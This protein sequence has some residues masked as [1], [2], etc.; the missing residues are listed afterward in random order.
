MEI[1]ELIIFECRRLCYFM[2]DSEKDA[3][4]I[5]TKRSNCRREVSTLSGLKYPNF[6]RNDQKTAEDSKEFGFRAFI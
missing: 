2:N 5:N 3:A 6:K 4:S 1:I